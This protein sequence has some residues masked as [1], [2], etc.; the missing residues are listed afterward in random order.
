VDSQVNNNSITSLGSGGGVIIHQGSAYFLNAQVTLNTSGGGMGSTLVGDFGSCSVGGSGGAGGG[1]N[2]QGS[3]YMVNTIIEKNRT[4][5]GGPGLEGDYSCNSGS[6]GH[7]GG[8]YNQGTAQIIYSQVSDNQTGNAG[9]ASSGYGNLGGSGGGLYN[10][11]SLALEYTHV[12]SNTTGD[13]TSDQVSDGGG[14]GI[15]NSGT[16]SM[17]GV[18][19][20]GNQTGISTIGGYGGGLYLTGNPSALSNL[21]IVDNQV[22]PGGKGSG[23][24]VYRTS[25]DLFHTTLARNT[26]GDGSGI[27][28]IYSNAALTNTI[29]VSQTVG[30]TVTSG[31]RINLQDVLL[32]SG[33]WANLLDFDG[34]GLI[35][36]THILTGDPAFMAPES[37]DY[38]IGLGSAALDQ[39]ISTSLSTDFDNQ[40]RPNPDTGLPD[41]GADEYWDFGPISS[42]TLSGPL[43]GNIYTP[44]PI[45]ASINPAAATP[46]VIYIWTPP[47]FT[48]QFTPHATFSWPEAGVYT[49][50][51]LAMNMDSQVQASQVVTIQAGE[52]MIYLPVVV[53]GESSP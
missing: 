9:W 23:A 11:G 8:I 41:L 33:A 15:Y 3:I 39:G 47:P 25:P 50:N 22:L 40:P 45:S 52:I 13:S 34:S 18:K 51:V 4:G 36:A 2:N 1:I 6:G 17:N 7:G 26:G 24:Y 46:N 5:D 29:L 16:L 43:S 27:L 21:M 10:A 38:H 42:V 35:S 37:G 14:G 48:G 31:S 20:A 30:I 44:L 49:V 19:L 28:F 12:I 53:R 32:G